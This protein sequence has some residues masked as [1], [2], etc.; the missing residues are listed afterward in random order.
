[1]LPSSQ[2]K[3]RIPPPNCGLTALCMPICSAPRSKLVVGTGGKWAAGLNLCVEAGLQMFGR[4][5]H[6]DY[7]SI[8]YK[9]SAWS[10]QSV[11]AAMCNSSTFWDTRDRTQVW[12]LVSLLKRCRDEEGVCLGVFMLSNLNADL[13][14]PNTNLVQE[15][16][17]SVVIYCI[18]REK[19]HS[20][21]A[22]QQI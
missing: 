7:F 11:S 5:V 20:F 16:Q 9:L 10:L 1:M 15:P 13:W 3:R 19:S 21:W 14:D 12:V 4:L 22:W 2:Q 18:C 6:T 17:Q 8:N